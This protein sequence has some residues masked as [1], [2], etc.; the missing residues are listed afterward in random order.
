[1]LDPGGPDADV[2]GASQTP[3]PL[4]RPEPDTGGES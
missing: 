1:M 3:D 2:H 4:T